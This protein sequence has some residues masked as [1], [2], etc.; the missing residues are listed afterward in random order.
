MKINIRIAVVFDTHDTVNKSV[1]S[2]EYSEEE[3]ITQCIEEELDE[4][5]M[6]NAIQKDNL[7]EI[8]SNSSCPKK[9]LK[10]P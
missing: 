3:V 8:I 7:K 6:I 2:G 9:V 4:K 10:K 5:D 1:Y